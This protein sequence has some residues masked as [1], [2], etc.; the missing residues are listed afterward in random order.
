LTRFVTIDDVT[1]AED[2]GLREALDVEKR[3]GVLANLAEGWHDG[4]GVAL[5][6]DGLVWLADLLSRA[7]EAGLSRP[8][9]YPTLD[10]DVVAEWPFATAEVSVDFDLRARSASL[11]GT[12]LRT[13][14]VLD[15]HFTFSDPAD[16]DEMV[17]AVTRFG[18]EGTVVNHE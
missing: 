11:V 18:P 1:Y 2:A 4:Q 15:V 14:A 6:S 3:L 8:Y 12:H 5:P 17:S 9:L 16:L 7:I 13:K 10:G